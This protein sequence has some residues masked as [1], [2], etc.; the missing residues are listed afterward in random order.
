MAYPIVLPFSQNNPL[1]GISSPPQGA[2]LRTPQVDLGPS[3]AGAVYTFFLTATSTPANVY[4]DEFLTTP[5]SPTGTVTADGFGRF[6]A[7]YLDNSITYKVTLTSAAISGGARTTDPYVVAMATTGNVSV[8]SA[9]G[10]TN[11]AQGEYTIE[12]PV[13]GGNGVTL[14]LNATAANLGAAL[15]LVGNQPG[16]PLLIINNSVTTGAHTATF[17]AANKPGTATSSPTGWLPI[18]CDGALYYTPLWFDNNFSRY[19]FPGSTTSAPIISAANVTFNG[20]G[21]LT[22]AGTG[23]TATPSNWFSP[24]QTGAGAGYYIETTIT[25]GLAGQT[26]T[27]TGAWTNIGSG[28]LL[29]SSNSGA[30]IT[31]TYQL[32]SS[33]TGVPVLANG[34]ITLSGGNGAQNPSISVGALTFNTD[35]TTTSMGGTAPGNWFLPTTAGEGSSYYLQMNVNPSNSNGALGGITSGAYTLMSPALSLYGI[36][37]GANG[38]SGTT[39][40][41][42]QVAGTYNISTTNSSAGIVVSGSFD[43]QDIAVTSGYPYGSLFGSDSTVTF[44]T[45]GTLIDSRFAW[46]NPITTG[47]GSSFWLTVVATGSGTLVGITNN[48]PTQISSNIVISTTGGNLSCNYTISNSASGA[49]ILCE[50][51]FGLTSTSF[52]GQTDTFNTAGTF[53]ETIPSGASQVVI[54]VWGASGGGGGGQTATKPFTIGGG[55][56]S[57]GYSRRT[58]AISSGNWGKTIHTVIGASG[59]DASAGAASTLS[60]GTFTMT[61]QNANGGGGGGTN[62]GGGA[63]GTSSGGTTNTPGNVGGPG[64]TGSSTGGAGIVGINGTGGSG[65]TGNFNS[66]AVGATGLAIFKYT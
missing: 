38:G 24:L 22:L 17:T 15:A 29:V 50:G 28:G 52:S 54:E 60:S 56:G 58:I 31:A 7:I 5:F 10:I 27:A 53:T 20:N 23:A 4:Q 2:L 9:I 47:I 61:T 41:T 35:G 18:E 64:G 43:L 33:V 51:S 16:T 3:F 39:F 12:A 30:L 45:N 59:G 65:G 36:A 44:F 66:G 34:T 14:T 40:N 62:G 55:G 19:T 37:N 25:S 1:T 26:L 11:N 42:G 57:G 8:N 46:Y 63:G 32:S 48:T 49:P 21:S 6:P 13:A